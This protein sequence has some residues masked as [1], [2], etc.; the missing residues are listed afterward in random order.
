M[1][2]LRRLLPLLLIGCAG[3]P[4]AEAEPRAAAPAAAVEE[5]PPP[6][7]EEPPP[8]PDGPIPCFADGAR[9]GGVDRE[10]AAARDLTVV[11]L[12]AGWTPAVFREHPE[13]G[14]AGRQPYRETFLRLANQD[15]G[16]R[17][18]RPA[19]GHLELYG[20]FP[21][22]HLHAARLG[23]EARHACHRA[24]DDRALEDL[25][26]GL[27][28]GAR[29]GRQRREAAA[30]RNLRR[31]LE[32]ARERLGLETVDA[33][34]GHR[35]FGRHLTRL[36]QLEPRVDAIRAVQAHLDCEGLLPARAR[37]GVLDA[38]TG[39]GL[40]AWQRMHMIIA[41]GGRLDAAT[42]RSLLLDSEE[43][44]L[45]ALLR[46]LRERV[47]AATGLIED[48]TAAGVFGE[49]A[50]RRIDIDDEFRW[51]ERLRP[52]P[53]GARDRV[54]E[55]TDA[56]ARALGWT[57]PAG[58]RAWLEAH[59]AERREEHLV[60]LPLPA[61]P[62]Y[63]GPH[64][65]LRVEIDRG[66]VWY[67]FPYTDDGRRRGYPVRRRPL[68][69]I[70]AR[71]EGRD[72]PL[73][74]WNT[75]IGG[76]QPE[77]T[78][79]GEVGLRYKN[80]DVGPRVWRDVV[81]SPAWLPPPSTPPR[82]LLRR[83]RDGTWRAN[84]TVTGPGYASAYG[85]AMVIHHIPH[86]DPERFGDNG[87]RS[88][89]SASYRSILRGYSHGCHRLFNHLAVRM[90]SF[91]LA[92]RRHAARGRLE[93]NFRRSLT[94]EPDEDDP[95]ALA[96]DPVSLRIDTRGFL[97]QL[98]PPVPVE[99]LR[100][101]VRPGPGRPLQGFYPLP[102]DLRAEAEAARAAEGEAGAGSP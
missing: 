16:R 22:L 31:R 88:H 37:D 75:T 82:E 13:L 40:R 15:R 43:L 77:V 27:R 45:L 9:V 49:V 20:I 18:G 78:P 94:P 90:T 58:A 91:L 50:G 11:D 46:T 89:G 48:G 93:A 63:H 19:E 83:R 53:G 87:I 47:V 5:E 76:W 68:L 33:L 62:A 30:V 3:A 69:T 86:A 73:L 102:E 2:R 35:R 60:A 29:V 74:R 7:P 14:P 61:A 55:A 24:V 39:R 51:V 96:P 1:P 12:G 84:Q 38:W 71:H 21:T 17:R 54:A 57:D 70:F 101:R 95:E 92:H 56:A 34:E 10:D 23:D 28:P 98:D 8:P 99:V 25:D 36:R 64:M 66:D 32:Q 26:E 85:L 100:G 59:A 6:P 80:S 52:L 65:D 4:P 42:R 72:V 79:E 97:F 44:D 67:G 41:I 81:A